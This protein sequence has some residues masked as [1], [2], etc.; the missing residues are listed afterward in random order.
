[1]SELVVF[2][3]LPTII[4]YFVLS[5]VLGAFVGIQKDVLSDKKSGFLTSKK[6]VLNN[7]SG[8]R[9]F[10]LIALFGALTQ[11]LDQIFTTYLIVT[12][13]GFVLMSVFIV[14]DYIFNVYKRE[15]HSPASEISAILVYFLGV[16][17][18]LGAKEV[19][20]ILAIALSIIISS[21]DIIHG[22]VLKISREEI[23]T[24]LKFAA[25]AFV[26]LPLLPDVKYS[27]LT[28]FESLGFAGANA[29][30]HPIWTTAFFNP[31]SLWLFV[32]VMSGISYIGYFL[33]KIFGS[34]SG[35]LLSSLMGGLV[36]STA[37]T[38]SMSEESKKY[39][40]N[41]SLYTTGTL[42]ASAVMF[43]RVIAI[44]AF[45]YASLL[46]FIFI[47]ALVMFVI[48]M[49][50]TGYF[51]YTSKKESSDKLS[52]EEKVQSPF[53]IT[54]ALKFAGFILLIKFIAA[55]GIIYKDIWGE[56]LFYYTLGIVSGLADVD[57]I[58]QTM[59]SDASSGGL[60]IVVAG[61]TILI[62]VMSN[63]LVKGTL[64]Y[65]FGES[66]FGKKVLFTF[67]ASALGGIVTLFII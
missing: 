11:Y 30:T 47:P 25:I 1:M 55:I 12:V 50:C 22:Y 53:S 26:I 57:A 4:F 51:Y 3:N 44:V 2:S 14:I 46:S 52:I 35:I 61:T 5:F 43:L 38:A 41:S 66:Q 64:A 45:V 36:S 15:N 54:P 13:F 18:F 17:V 7:F 31:Y 21:R 9:S 40:K 60:G 58:T 19:A 24:T 29:I 48:F 49:L 59:A 20:I 28:F 8:I 39:P 56:G 63:N 33:T 27:F 62:A 42:L 6:E 23:N 67:V 32:V 37:V 65:R 10:G 34:T 16:L